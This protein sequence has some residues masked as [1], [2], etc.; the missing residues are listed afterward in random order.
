MYGPP[1]DCKGIS[2]NEAQ[3]VY[4]QHLA[5]LL[6]ISL[7][8]ADHLGRSVQPSQDKA[9]IKRQVLAGIRGHDGHVSRPQPIEHAECSSKAS[10]FEESNASEGLFRYVVQTGNTAT[11]AVRVSELATVRQRFRSAVR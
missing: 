7:R 11:A 4:K 8:V 3:S 1:R 2:P 9:T 10:N 6:F 5:P